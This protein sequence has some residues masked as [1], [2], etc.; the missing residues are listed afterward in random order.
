MYLLSTFNK[1]ARLFTSV[2]GK[3]AG[4]WKAS[5]I[6]ELPL[7]R[8][9]KF[10]LRLVGFFSY[11]SKWIVKFSNKIAPLAYT[12][13]FPVPNAAQAAFGDLKKGDYK[14]RERI[15][16]IYYGD[17]PFRCCDGHFKSG[18][19]TNGIFSWMLNHSEIKQCA[20]ENAVH[21]NVESVPKW[22]RYLSGRYFTI[23]TNQKSVAFMFHTMHRS[24]IRIIRYWVGGWN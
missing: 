15:T 5:S 13:S 1:F 14:F 10:L 22:R 3:L 6:L 24:N 17:G 23:I 7:S 2:K 4:S 18:R 19:Q 9:M 16:A 12:T 8:D 20:V 21:A 11:Y